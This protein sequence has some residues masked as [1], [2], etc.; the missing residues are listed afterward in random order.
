MLSGRFGPVHPFRVSGWAYDG[1]APDAPVEVEVQLDGQALG[2]VRADGPSAD[3]E[4]GGGRRGFVLNT[5]QRLPTEAV[6]RLTVVA[7]SADGRSARL[8]FAVPAASDLRYPMP[9]SDPA[10]RPVFILGS[11][12]L[13]DDRRDARA[14]LGDALCRSRRGT[15]SRH[16]G[17]PP[18][19]GE[20]HLRGAAPPVVDR[21]RHDDHGR[22]AGIHDG[23]GPARLRRARPHA[24]HDPLL[25]RQDADAVHDP[26]GAGAEDGLARSAF[27]L[28]EAAGDREPAVPHAAISPDRLRRPLPRLGGRPWTTGSGSATISARARS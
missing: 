21:P 3:P 13:R 18:L 15:S 8:G 16:A 14:P 22:A 1:D 5:S 20:P 26:R 19:G 6:D 24:V 28:L 2:T 4:A 10:Q 23:R 11:G 9:A 27:R 7:R 25:A 12:P 17:A